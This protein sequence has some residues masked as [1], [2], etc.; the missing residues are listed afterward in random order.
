VLPL[1]L[2]HPRLAGTRYILSCA[3][4]LCDEEEYTLK[5]H[6]DEKAAIMV[7]LERN[8]GNVPYTALQVGIPERTLYHWQRKIAARLLQHTPHPQYPA[9]TSA[10]DLP[11]FE[12]DLAR[13]AFIRQHI[14]AEMT[15]LSTVLGTAASPHLAY[16]RVLI[17]SHLIDKLMKLDAHLKPY[18]PEEAGMIRIVIV[19]EDGIERPYKPSTDDPEDYEY[20]P[21][22]PYAEW[23]KQQDANESPDPDGGTGA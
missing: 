20:R 21:Y 8:G 22:D 16:Q 3:V 5:Y 12:D 4:R 23:L 2:Y 14:M 15:R 11:V 18:Q 19:D 7:L 6:S 17:L 1:S 10:G 9:G 13:L